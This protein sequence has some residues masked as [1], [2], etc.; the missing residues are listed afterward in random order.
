M[1]SSVSVFLGGITIKSIIAHYSILP[2]K[3][4]MVGEVKERMVKD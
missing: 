3:L 1:K 2:S 4:L